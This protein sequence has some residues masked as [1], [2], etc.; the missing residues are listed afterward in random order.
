MMSENIDDIKTS[1]EIAEFQSDWYKNADEKEQLQFRVWLFSLLKTQIILVNFKK[2]DG[3]I[4]EMNCTLLDS[5]IPKVENPKMSE[6]L[7]TVWD[8]DLSAW[9]SFKFE[10]ITNVKFKIG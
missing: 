4:R 9:R 6:T 2:A 8:T 10:N 7:C 1:D 5:L 3:T